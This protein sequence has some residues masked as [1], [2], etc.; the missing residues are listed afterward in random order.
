MI[1]FGNAAG[2]LTESNIEFGETR[3]RIQRIVGGED[4]YAILGDGNRHTVIP[5]YEALD[6]FPNVKRF[7]VLQVGPRICS[8]Y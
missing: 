8:T 5:F 3:R 2:R 7:Q 1:R 4:D 6:V